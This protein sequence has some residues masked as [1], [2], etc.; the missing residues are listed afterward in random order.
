MLDDPRAELLAQYL[1]TGWSLDEELAVLARQPADKQHIVEQR[2]GVIDSYLNRSPQTTGDA[3][4][5][6]A[7]IGV[8]RRQFYS[9][10]SKL[11]ELGPSRALTPGFRN[12]LRAA[13]SRDGLD[14]PAE[15]AIRD[16]LKAEP[17]ARLSRIEAYVRQVCDSAG[18]GFPGGSAIKRRVHV[19]RQSVDFAA[20]GDFG[21]RLVIDQV[22]LELSVSVGDKSTLSI[23]TL[24]IDRETRLIAGAGLTAV[25]KN[26]LG[27]NAAVM[28]FAKRR[29]RFLAS[30]IPVAEAIKELTWVLPPG[31]QFFNEKIE[32]SFEVW[33]RPHF[34]FVG[35]P[36]TRHGEWI[37]RLIGDRLGPFAFRR[38]AKFD[39]GLPLSTTPGISLEDARRLVSSAIDQWNEPRL[40]AAA[41]AKALDST[42][43][44]WRL[45]KVARELNRASITLRQAADFL[46]YTMFGSGAEQ[47]DPEPSE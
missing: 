5:A 10:V 45:R 22:P 1:P 13:P 36:A 41:S 17:E 29:E 40:A 32:Q 8:G 28:D 42:I 15:G 19:L 31:M 20:P 4:F 2:L 21:A 44:D 6:A 27:L 46:F 34:E 24:I 47:S 16:I 37:M 18:A 38:L 3:D 23:I 39:R 43:R 9:L 11:R 14:E 30:Q 12:V 26:G 33:R 25:E 7:Q 35:H